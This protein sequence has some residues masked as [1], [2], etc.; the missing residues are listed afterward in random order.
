MDGLIGLD[1]N[2][3]FTLAL[4]VGMVVV[5]VRDLARPDFVLLACVGLLLLAGILTP[6]QAFAGFS[7]S[8]VL[9]V[10]ALFIVARGLERTGALGFLDGFLL[11]KSDRPGVY[12]PRLM[13]PTS[14]LSAFL[15][16][17][18]IVAM[19]MPRVQQW[20]ER[21][22]ISPSKVLMPLSFAAILGGMTTLI[23]T[24]TNIVVSGLMEA[25]GM[26]PMGM[27]EIA[28]IGVPAAVIVAAYL[29][30]VGHRLLP[31]RGSAKA[32]FEDGLKECL[33][34]IRIDDDPAIV[35]KTVEEAGLRA[36]GDAFLV[37]IRRG[38]RFIPV[39]PQLSL[40]AGDILSF[41]G[42]AEMI[43]KLLERPGMV[44]ALESAAAA[45]GAGLPIF[46]AVVADSSPLVGRTLRQV[47]FRE[48]Y[49]GVVLAIQR[50][51]QQLA[52][53]L[54]RI[55]IDAGD[56]LLI[57]AESNFA[58]KWNSS[59]DDFYLV[60]PRINGRTASRT[61]RAPVA[62]AILA[63]MI[64]AVAFG[65]MPIVTAAFV[66]ALG[67]IATRCLTFADAKESVDFP[68]LL[69]IA[70]ALGV[71]KAVEITGL[72]QAGADLLVGS[73]GFL[74]P[75]GLLAAV[76]VS[77]NVLTELITHKAAAVLMFPVAV[78]A[79]LELGYDPRPFVFIVAIGAAASF[80]TPI[81]YQTNLMVLAAGSYRYRDFVRCGLPVAVLVLAIAVV[82]ASVVWL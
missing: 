75:I 65:I 44:R 48:T 52:G 6:E 67:M 10:G 4:I 46:E 26:Q 27:F 24:S 30:L 57:E 19:F 37:H 45:E 5:L 77:T 42:K 22:G 49:G 21:M 54:G 43:D 74:G 12:L 16:N 28:W 13:L 71:G 23:G 2:A 73:T 69:I 51:N 25:A 7:N 66:A 1:W 50:K 60:A 15:N 53:S 17:T 63:A 79:A 55:R 47:G 64:A 40:Q 70:A 35:D 33:F 18:P 20:S 32:T 58:R 68:V 56:L 8:A 80:V 14:I 29:A 38:R 61:R 9:A 78:A 81:G 59:R 82:A 3:W 39:R 76:Y 41:S 36:L 34:E 11:S 31:D 62:A 72:A